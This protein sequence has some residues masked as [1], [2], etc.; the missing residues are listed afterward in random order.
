MARFIIFLCELM[1]DTA[2]RRSMDI[3]QA[4][5]QIHLP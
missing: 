5:L 2:K 4:S 3:S 1:A